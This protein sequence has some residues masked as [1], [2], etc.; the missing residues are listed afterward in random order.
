MYKHFLYYKFYSTINIRMQ[1]RYVP[2]LKN[3]NGTQWAEGTWTCILKPILDQFAQNSLDG[4]TLVRYRTKKNLG[5]NP[6]TMRFH[7]PSNGRPL[8]P[9]HFLD[10][11]ITSFTY[12]DLCKNKTCNTKNVQI[13]GCFLHT[14]F[15]YHS[16]KG[17][18]ISPLEMRR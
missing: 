3:M 5:R 18:K 17:K 7:R 12:L 14:K 16:S 10:K 9:I 6:L 4:C 8:N 1:I 11:D 15:H 13:R 2:S